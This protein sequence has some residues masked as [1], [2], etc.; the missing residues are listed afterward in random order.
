M[1]PSIGQTGRVIGGALLVGGAYV[2]VRF[3]RGWQDPSGRPLSIGLIGVTLALVVVGYLL[4]FARARIEVDSERVLKVSALGGGRSFQ[5]SAV[6][7]VAFRIVHQ[8]LSR[9]PDPTFGVVYGRDRRGLFIFSARLWDPADVRRLTS[10]FGGRDPEVPPTVSRREFERE[11]PGAFNVWERHPY[12]LGVLLTIVL[13]VGLVVLV[14][15]KG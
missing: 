10:L 1:R 15:W 8:P 11:F 12:V 6:G 2:A 13:L 7:G 5:R 3:A 9:A 14:R 4:F